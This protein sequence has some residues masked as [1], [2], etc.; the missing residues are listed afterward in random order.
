M[1]PPGSIG[2]IIV[3]YRNSTEDLARLCRKLLS[4][5]SAVGLASTTYIVVND[6]SQ[7]YAEPG[8]TV[9]SG[10]GNVGFAGGI[11]MAVDIAT[12]DYLIFLN[13]DCDVSTEQVEAFICESTT[14]AGIT[15]PVIETS[16]G[17][18]DY[19]T[20]EN[21]TFTPGRMI[22]AYLC[23]HHLLRDRSSD[24]LPRYAKI[25]GAFVG[26][27][28]QLAREL[29]SPFDPEFFLYAED[30]D[31]TR[32]VRKRG[33]DI[34]FVKSVRIRHAGGV[35]GTSVSELVSIAKSDGSIRVASRRFG[36]FGV[37]L[38]IFDELIFDSIRVVIGKKVPWSSRRIAAARWKRSGLRNPGSL[39]APILR[40][41]TYTSPDAR[42]ATES[43]NR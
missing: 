19:Q 12:E 18:F 20:Y 23:Q 24:L 39:T 32:R 25:S 10:H 22:S 41:L 5:A 29:K 31:L 21:W 8:V 36:R 43:V 33:I 26:M 7:I 4:S 15:V 2:Y 27:P 42:G 28:L 3:A 1:K 30:R 6:E 40:D 37:A 38:Y 14:R 13:P 16:A 9:I 35:S 17:D 34:H 11:K